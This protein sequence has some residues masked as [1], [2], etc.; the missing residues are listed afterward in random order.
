MAMARAASRQEQEEEQH[1]FSH[2]LGQ[3]VKCPY[4]DGRQLKVARGVL[5]SARGG[6]IKI[7]GNL[8]TII[9]NVRN[10]EKMSLI[11]RRRPR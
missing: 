8:G 9:I 2:F 11:S 10:I 1:I 5:V 7:D 4:R 3:E 6:F